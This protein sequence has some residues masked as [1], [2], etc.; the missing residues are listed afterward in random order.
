M[1]MKG[2]LMGVLVIAA[3]VVVGMFLL[4]YLPKKA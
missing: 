4:Q 3:G 1:A 2:S